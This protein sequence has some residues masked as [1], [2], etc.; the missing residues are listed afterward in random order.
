MKSK[1]PAIIL[2]YRYPYLS[3]FLSDAEG[4]LTPTHLL[5]QSADQQHWQQGLPQEGKALKHLIG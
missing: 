1:K 3:P 2:I 4:W 5:E